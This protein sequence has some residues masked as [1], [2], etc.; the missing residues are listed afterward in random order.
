MNRER[1][2]PCFSTYQDTGYVFGNSAY[3]CCRNCARRNGCPVERRG[4]KCTPGDYDCTGCTRW[5]RR[6]CRYFVLDWGVLKV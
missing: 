3:T 1:P 2:A 6:G 4:K 5:N